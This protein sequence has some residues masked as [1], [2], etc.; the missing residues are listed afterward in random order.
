MRRNRPRAVLRLVSSLAA[1]ASVVAVCGV[2]LGEHPSSALAVAALYLLPPCAIALVLLSGRYP[3]ARALARLGRARDGR[4]PR[5]AS[6]S[7]PRQ[8]AAVL[9]RGGRLIAV[10]LAGRAPPPAA[11]CC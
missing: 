1:I 6:S 5:A 4:S 9:L 3:G 10:S 8:H 7:A 11:A 2:L